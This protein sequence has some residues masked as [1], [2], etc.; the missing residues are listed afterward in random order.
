MKLDALKNIKHKKQLLIISVVVLCVAVIGSV[1]YKNVVV[2]AR[3]YSEAV[4]LYD[5]YDYAAAKEKFLSISD[6]KDSK[7]LAADC[8]TKQT[9]NKYS[10]AVSLYDGGDYKKAM[11]LFKELGTYKDSIYMYE[12]CREMMMQ[13]SVNNKIDPQYATYYGVVKSRHEA[14]SEG[15]PVKDKTHSKAKNAYNVKG[16]NLIKLVDL[17]LDGTEELIVGYSTGS[18]GSGNYEIYTYKNG[19]TELIKSGS[20]EKRSGS[21]GYYALELYAYS[22]GFKLCHLGV[23]SGYTEVFD[24]NKFVT[25]SKWKH[26]GKKYTVNGKK[27]NADDYSA[28]AISYDTSMIFKNNKTPI[29]AYQYNDGNFTVYAMSFLSESA[30]NSLRLN[31]EGVYKTLESSYNRTKE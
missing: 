11:T 30:V 8:D 31:N 16:V 27:V 2:V 13:Q 23:G 29:S 5:E 14:Y 21:S 19:G 18:D 15:K 10:N 25:D 24:G 17:N 3:T 1:Y 4:S 22:D 20:Y 12:Q 28:A 9:E 7:S 6:Y 26:S